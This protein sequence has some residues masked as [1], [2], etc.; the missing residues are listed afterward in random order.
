M[1]CCLPLSK[2]AMRML[3]QESERPSLE[4]PHR[5]LDSISGDMKHLH[6]PRIN[7]GILVEARK[8]GKGAGF[9]APLS[10]RQLLDRHCTG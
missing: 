5:L 7:Y 10:C 3:A 1:L 9:P 8:Q 6:Q 4:P 2:T